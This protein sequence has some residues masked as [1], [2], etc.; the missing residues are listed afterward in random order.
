MTGIKICGIT[1]LEDALS[2]QEAGADAL[3]F[4]F[5]ESP[6]RIDVGRAARI[7][8]RL[9]NGVT[10]VGVFVDAS[11]EE[12]KGV[13]QEVGL[14]LVQLHGS[15][16]PAF[17]R[18]L[19]VPALKAFR[20]RNADVIESIR[21][22]GTETFL[23]DAFVKGRAGGTGRRVDLA[24]AKRASTLG[25]MVLAGGLDPDNVAGVVSAVRPDAVD[26]S[27]SLELRP[28]LKDKEKMRRFVAEVRRCDTRMT[29]GASAP[30]EDGLFRKSCRA[31]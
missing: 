4:V 13:V 10:L 7:A 31:H 9:G 21:S 25:R 3:G 18:R 1:H 15:E 29:R 2:A 5:A 27:S 19:G 20:A 12:V 11:A 30:S 14:D 26:A 8:R 22:F 6:R 28:G 24:L 23:L 16:G 17:A